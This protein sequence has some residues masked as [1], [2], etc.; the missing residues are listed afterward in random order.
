MLSHQFS[1][2]VN[3][4]RSGSRRFALTLLWVTAFTVSCLLSVHDVITDKAI[5]A[6]LLLGFGNAALVSVLLKWSLG[7]ATGLR[8]RVLCHAVGYLAAAVFAVFIYLHWQDPISVL[9]PILGV[10]PALVACIFVVPLCR[11]RGDLPLWHLL[12]RAITG[13]G[14]SLITTSLLVSGVIGL[15]SYIFMLFDIP[16]K[17]DFEIDVAVIGFAWLAPVVL[18]LFLPDTQDRKSVV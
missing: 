10:E 5:L 13:L 18:L 3:S 2:L 8:T 11:G 12:M 4:L 9:M 7:A 1:H 15:F 16:S 17:N 14:V 6:A